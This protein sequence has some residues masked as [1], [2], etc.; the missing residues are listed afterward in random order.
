[1]KPVDFTAGHC[2][3]WVCYFALENESFMLDFVPVNQWVGKLNKSDTR[4]ISYS[5][6]NALRVFLSSQN[7]L[8]PICV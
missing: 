6:L 3:M 2:Q 7:K 1:M 4:H 5:R 8:G